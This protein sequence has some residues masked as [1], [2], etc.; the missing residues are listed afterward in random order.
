M[1]Q[2]EGAIKLAK[3]SDNILRVIV[4]FRIFC[5]CVLLVEIITLIYLG[6]AK[7][8]EERREIEK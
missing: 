1:T 2:F 4:H 3:H 7:S 8:H 6:R 5:K